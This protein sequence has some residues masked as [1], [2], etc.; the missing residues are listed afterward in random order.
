MEL[1]SILG[2]LKNKTI[3]ITG[4][5]GFVGKVLVEKI[6]RVQPDVKRL[7]LLL[8]ASDANSATQRMHN[9]ITGKE[10]FR[11]LREKLGADFD[12]Y[13]LEKVVA[14]SGDVIFQDLG[15]KPVK[16]KEEMCNEVQII[17]NSAAITRFD[18]RYDVA[19]DVNT[20]GVLN[21]LDFAKKCLKLE[22]VV[23][24][25]TAY[26][27]GERAGLILEDSSSMDEMA[28]KPSK[29]DLKSQEKKMVENK[30]KELQAQN[31]SEE[32]IT[33]AMKD[34]GTAR[35]KLYG[36]ANTYVLTKVMGEMYLGHAKGNLSVAIIRPT[37]ITST[38][39]EPFSGW[40]E[41]FRTY[42]SVIGGYWKGKLTGIPVDPMSVVDMIPVDMVVNSIITAMVVNANKSGKIIYHLGTS[43]RNPLTFSDFN[44]FMFQY[45]TK[46]PW[47]NN[48]GSPVKVGK[49]KMLRSMDTFH[50]YMQIPLQVLK[51]MN[52]EFDQ[53]FQDVYVNYN[54]KVKLVK[55]L[56]EFYRAYLL[57]KGIFDDTNAEE[58]RRIASENYTDAD[59]FNFDP[60]CID[61]E[62]YYMH[63]HIPGF[64][65]HV[66]IKHSQ[67]RL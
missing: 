24:V 20:F 51:F 44:N 32:V 12:S 27:C 2:Y 35:S 7:Y 8:R 15:V 65:K 34:L 29:F 16:L 48:D 60:K 19:L 58:L 40:I 63:T 66:V 57:F 13:I 50:L 45:C 6:L 46:N 14:L 38:Y 30:L 26:V 43:L 37:M 31:A 49:L 36:W 56:V 3:L 53:Y 23:H 9:E 1:E 61:W 33:S 11:V 41:G 22:M 5:T 17:L 59:N 67:S 21:M 55:R 4:A 62:D 52:K 42:D 18:E 10:L 25:S 64:A 39:K 54:R 28:K 47:L